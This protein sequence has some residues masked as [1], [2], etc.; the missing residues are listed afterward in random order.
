MQDNPN[1]QPSQPN[2][3]NNQG[4]E[5]TRMASPKVYS[6]DELNSMKVS[7]IKAL[8]ESLGYSITKIIKAEIIEEFIAQQGA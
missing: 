6:Y 1:S 2:Q 8:A 3:D 5:Q 4:D 7:E